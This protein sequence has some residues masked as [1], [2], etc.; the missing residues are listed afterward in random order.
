MLYPSFSII[1][2]CEDEATDKFMQVPGRRIVRRRQ[3]R[4]LGELT[5]ILILRVLGKGEEKLK[6]QQWHGRPAHVGCVGFEEAS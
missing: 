6:T 2:V 3:S 4:A 5:L 1:A